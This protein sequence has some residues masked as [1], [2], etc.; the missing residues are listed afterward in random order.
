MIF[1]TAKNNPKAQNTVHTI[2]P[3]INTCLNGNGVLFC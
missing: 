3:H 2:I 1:K